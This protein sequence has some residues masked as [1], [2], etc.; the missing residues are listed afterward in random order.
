MITTMLR[1]AG[2]AAL[3]LAC[4]PAFAQDTLKVAVG[5]R[6]LWDTSISDLG[7]RA[8]IFKKHGLTLEILYT[9]ASARPSRP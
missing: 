2:I 3:A 8:G 4:A 9:Q 6:G 7:Q 1:L 5:Q